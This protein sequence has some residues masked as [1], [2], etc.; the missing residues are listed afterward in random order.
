MQPLGTGARHLWVQPRSRRRPHL[1][2]QRHREGC[3]VALQ[4]AAALLCIVALCVLTVHGCGAASS[5]LLGPRG[6]CSSLLLEW[7]P[8]HR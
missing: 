4:A 7:L 2:E 5:L 3:H 1:A 6:S 8:L